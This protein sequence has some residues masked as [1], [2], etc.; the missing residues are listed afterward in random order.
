MDNDTVSLHCKIKT[1]FGDGCPVVGMQICQRHKYATNKMMEARQ[2]A[3]RTI[4]HILNT[5][6]KKAYLLLAPAML[7][8][9]V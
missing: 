2:C 3:L 8:I 5:K 6:Q 1:A 7:S 9:S 4:I